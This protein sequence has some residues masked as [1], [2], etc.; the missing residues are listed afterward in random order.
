[1]RGTFQIGEKP[2]KSVNVSEALNVKDGTTHPNRTT[3]NNTER[4]PD[5][6]PKCDKQMKNESKRQ[7]RTP[8]P[9][10]GPRKPL[11]NPLNSHSTSHS[12]SPLRRRAGCG[13]PSR[14]GKFHHAPFD[15][16]VEWGNLNMPHS[17]GQRKVNQ[18]V[19]SL[20]QLVANLRQ[21]VA[22]LCQL[23]SFPHSSLRS[24]QRLSKTLCGFLNRPQKAVYCILC[25]VYC[26]PLLP[27]SVGAS[28][29]QT[30]GWGAI[31]QLAGHDIW[32]QI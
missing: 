21:L 30:F 9:P 16:Q 6:P 2:L 13:P 22:N 3:E 23:F 24:P 5:L 28:G 17:T 32:G 15:L 20:R 14:M 26:L 11:P 25:I 8:G 4:F 1:L 29:T 31:G 7:A 27:A 10:G 12:T 18:L 19:A